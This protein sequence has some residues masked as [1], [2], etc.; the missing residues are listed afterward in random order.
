MHCKRGKWKKKKNLLVQIIDS[1]YGVA[2]FC[3]FF[4]RKDSKCLHVN[5]YFICIIFNDK[6]AKWTI[7]GTD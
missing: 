7:E 6:E 5:T 2:V 1:W 4:K 3:F